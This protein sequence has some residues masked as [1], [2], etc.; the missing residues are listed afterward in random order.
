[1]L[2]N[3]QGPVTIRQ[4]NILTYPTLNI[5]QCP[6]LLT[7][8]DTNTG[9]VVEI[10]NP[11]IKQWRTE[12]IDHS[13][14]I[15]GRPEL[16]I[17]FLGVMECPGHKRLIGEEEYVGHMRLTVDGA[18]RRYEDDDETPAFAARRPAAPSWLPSP[19]SSSPSLLDMSPSPNLSSL[20][21]PSSFTSM[22]SSHSNQALNTPSPSPDYEYSMFSNST[23]LSTSSPSP[24]ALSADTYDSLWHLGYAHVPEGKGSWPAGMFTRDMAWGL[25]RLGEAR[26]DVETR[27]KQVFPGAAWVRATYYRHRDA[28]FSST[29]VEIEHCHRLPRSAGGLWS[30]WRAYSTG[31][32]I[33]ADK[34]KNGSCK[35]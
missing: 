17:R 18:K 29:T 26:G 25:T 2:Q 1:M 9:A 27:F 3:G 31:W 35:R 13:M 24:S 19:S 8:M 4:Q 34:K 12:D 22:S 33:V 10:W 7:K 32:K 14:S 20:S 6:T 21:L 15:K 28:F 5:A 16:L 11:H 23:A 30:D